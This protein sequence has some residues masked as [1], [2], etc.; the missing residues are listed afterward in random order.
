LFRTLP[1]RAVN[2]LTGFGHG[3]AAFASAAMNEMWNGIKRVGSNILGWFGGFVKSIVGFFA[4]LL[5]HSP[6]G[7]FYAMGRNM[8][9]GL[10]MGLKDHAHLVANASKAAASAAAAGKAGA[11]V[12][13]WRPLVLRALR[14]EHLPAGLVN[15]VLYQMQTESGGAV[16]AIN[17][18]DSNAAAGMPSKGLMQVIWPTFAAYH[19]PGTSWDQYNPLANIAAAINYGAH[20]GRGF[21]SGPGQIGSGHGYDHGGWL[22]TGLSLAWNA[23]GRPE[24]VL[25]PGETGHTTINI[26]VNVPPGT[27]KRAVAQELADVLLHHTK[28]GGRL[29]PQ[30]VQPR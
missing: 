10:A 22:P 14:M 3:L 15:D 23:T 11:G 9:E 8:M 13:Q 16:R 24:R 21:G 18:T 7:E 4:R 28:A 30:G 2:A 29:Y 17:L 26:N 20:N 1:G 6:T 19:W 12:Q 25:G 5:H 27:N